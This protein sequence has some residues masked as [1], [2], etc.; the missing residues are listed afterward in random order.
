MKLLRR[1]FLHL[2]A[3]A[4]A[5][6]ALSRVAGAQTY[7]M[8]PAR[9]LVGFPAGGAADTIVR[10]MA[11]WLSDRLGQSFVVENRPGAATNLALQAALTSPPDEVLIGLHLDLNGD[12]HH[13]E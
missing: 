12:Q 13:T 8:R 4:A 3:G 5:L 11:Q 9:I 7:P 10:I 1:D 6:P 2:A